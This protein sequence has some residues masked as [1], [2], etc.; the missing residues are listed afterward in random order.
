MRYRPTSVLL[1]VLVLFQLF[2]VY[3][4]T[5]SSCH[6]EPQTPTGLTV[7]TLTFGV[8]WDADKITHNCRMINGTRHRFFIYTD[9]LSAPYCRLCTC[10]RFK[11]SRCPPPNPK[12]GSR[13]NCE[14]S[15]FTSRIVPKLGEMVY[16]DSDLI[17]MRRDFLDRLYW[18]SRGHDFLASYGHAGYGKEVKYYNIM[19]SGLFF[20]RRVKSADYSELVPRMYRMQTG[21]DQTVLTGFVHQYYK[22]WDSLSWRWHCR[23]MLRMKQDTPLRECYTIHDRVE[24][25]RLL[26]MM[27]YTLLTI[28][29]S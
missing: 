11:P 18:R 13:N 23:D 29:T 3:Q 6:V 4:L 20:M 19:N 5:F 14:K 24:Y 28:P 27:N 17:I 26:K 9:D 7:T 15:V 22:H 21:F 8:P 2:E 25:P 1:L 12:A 10:Y 16:L